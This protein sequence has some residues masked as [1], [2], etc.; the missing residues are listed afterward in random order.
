MLD[1]RQW[2]NKDRLSMELS[3]QERGILEFEQAWW[4]VPGSK[5][6]AIRER[7]GLSSTRYYRLLT[8]LLNEPAAFAHDPLT[9]KRLQRDRERRRRHRIEGRRADPGSR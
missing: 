9:V 4:R 3:E 2:S 7:F 6:E 8:A 1:P 5:E